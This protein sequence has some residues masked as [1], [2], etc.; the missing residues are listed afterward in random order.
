MRHLLV[1]PILLIPGCLAFGQAA[2]P[3]PPDARVGIEELRKEPF[4]AHMAFLADDL[5]EGRGTGKRGH[6]IA[7]RYVAAQ[8]E[9]MGLKP[10]GVD[11][12]YYQRVPLRE[13]SVEPG[14]C[15]ISITENGSTSLLK[16][17][18]DFIM[19]GSPDDPD[20]SVEAPAVF[21]GYGVKTPD[22]RYDDYAGV[23]VQGKIVVLMPGA[24][25]SLPSELRAHLSSQLE[26]LRSAT[27][28][29]AVGMLQLRVPKDEKNLPWS[30]VVIGVGF[31]SMRWLA[32]DGLPRD[33]DYCV[34]WNT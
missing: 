14:K 8:F 22:G 34:L 12:T 9:A 3:I 33:S 1:L 10:A 15:T 5:L 28:H 32:P 25:P 6:E 23:D 31:P 2:S 19:R 17:G 24:P 27:N 16:W 26:K 29:G 13:I 18:D 20:A 21:V 11:G 30:R 4:H 7:A